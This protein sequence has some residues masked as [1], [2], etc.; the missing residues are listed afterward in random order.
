[1]KLFRIL[2]PK[3]IFRRFFIVKKTLE[4]LNGT[5]VLFNEPK[6]RNQIFERLK[7]ISREVSLLLQPHEAFQLFSIVRAVAKIS[8]DMAE[9]GVYQGGSAKIILEA[10]PDKVLHLFDTFEGLP[11]PTAKDFPE[12]TFEGGEYYAL[13]EP[14]KEY[15]KNYPQVRLYKGIF[16]QTAGPVENRKFSFINIDVDLYQ[17]TYD[18]LAFFYPRMNRGGVIMSHDYHKPGGVQKAIREFFMDKPEVVFETVGSQC[19]IVKL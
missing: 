4:K 16:P 12:H 17:A 5:V 6:D 15:L 10:E 7:L 9:V 19:F 2:N 3:N 11:G 13:L 1:M 8:G 14:V 18:S